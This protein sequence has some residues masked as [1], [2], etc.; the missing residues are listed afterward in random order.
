ME[1]LFSYFSYGYEP[2]TMVFERGLEKYESVG[3]CSPLERRDK[4]DNRF[5]FSKLVTGTILQLP[6]RNHINCN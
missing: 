5:S 3:R 2:E 1:A 6:L 4:T